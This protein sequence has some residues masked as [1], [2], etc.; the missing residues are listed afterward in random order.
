M[1]YN[2]AHNGDLQLQIRPDEMGA[3]ATLLL[4]LRLNTN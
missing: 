2:V 3:V 4:P 1:R